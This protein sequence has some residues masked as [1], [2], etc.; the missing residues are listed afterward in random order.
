MEGEGRESEERVVEMDELAAQPQ[1]KEGT[2]DHG[3]G[4]HYQ[5]EGEIVKA[6]A[7]GRV[8]EGLELG[9]LLAL[10]ADQPGQGRAGH[11]GGN[12]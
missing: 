11:E 4:D 2:S 9:D 12:A 5:G 7:H 1:T 10:Q 8:A 6:Y 3:Q